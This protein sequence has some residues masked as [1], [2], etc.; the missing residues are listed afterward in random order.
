MAAS[1]STRP[2]ERDTYPPK[3]VDATDATDATD[4]VNLHIHGPELCNATGQAFNILDS[5]CYFKPEQAFTLQLGA[6][7]Q[8]CG[9]LE[10][11]E[12]DVP[13]I[14]PVRSYNMI[15]GF[16]AQPWR[17]HVIT[18]RAVAAAVIE[19]GAEDALCT[20]HIMTP[21]FDPGYWG[22][23]RESPYGPITGTRSLC[24][25]H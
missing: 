5:R 9:T 7:P 22:G 19:A 4:A 16:P 11:G 14:S 3:F 6:M 1:A 12:L 24:L 20:G 15:R 25:Y 10:I 17:G 21:N 8:R 13:L 2:H 23:V 18:S